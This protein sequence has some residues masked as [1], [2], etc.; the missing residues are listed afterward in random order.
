VN[1]KV[2]IGGE[3]RRVLVVLLIFAHANH[4]SST[5]AQTT[6]KANCSSEITFSAEPPFDKSLYENDPGKRIALLD[7]FVA[8]HPKSDLLVYVYPLYYDAY[9]KIKNFPMVMEYAEK[10]LALSGKLTVPAEYNALRAWTGAYNSLNSD[11]VALAAKA[12]ARSNEGIEVV[13]KM[14]IPQSPCVDATTFESKKQLATIY[15]HAT[16]GAAAMKLKNYGAASGSLKA[17]LTLQDEL[18]PSAPST[19]N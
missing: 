2:G 3:M 15:F 1:F 6:P 8:K 18:F 13:S 7:E 5:Q 9:G 17:I 19:S 14:E 16:A 4:L 10:V 11:D 12:I